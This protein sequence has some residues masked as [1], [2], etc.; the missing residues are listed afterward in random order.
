MRRAVLLALPVVLALAS[1]AHA[2][3]IVVDTLLRGVSGPLCDIGD[4]LNAAN[5]DQP[6]G[7][8]Q[9][10]DPSGA[11]VIDLTGL[12]GVIEIEGN[13]LPVIQQDVTL[14]GPG[15]DLLTIDGGDLSEI[16][17]VENGTLTVE[18]LTIANGNS[19]RGGCIAVNGAGL[20]LRD[21]RVTSCVGF[22]GGGISVDGGG[23]ARIE[24]SLLDGNGTSGNSG[25][26]I[27]NGGSTLEIVSST[28][29]GN[30]TTGDGRVGGG[31]ATF[32]PEGPGLAT[33]RIRSSTIA[34]NGADEGGNVYTEPG[35]GA[36]TILSH[37]L[38]AG[39]RLG[40]NCGGAVASQGWNLSTDATCALAGAGDRPNAV[41]GITALTDAGGATALHVLEAGSAAIDGGDPAGCTDALGAP[42]PFDQ[43]G[44][45]FARRSDGNL[46]GS[47]E[48]D[49]GAYE[50]QTV[51]EPLATASGVAALAALAVAARAR[52]G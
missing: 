1:H 26:G 24:R 31:V 13:V 51:P 21:S 14:R 11:D 32:A 8:C 50:L 44:A 5:E 6:S 10:V 47:F 16:F 43:R 45:G 39:A 41:A 20:V 33:T 12:A 18:G 4:A 27:V 23:S 49:I 34:D 40:G 38:L 35:E 17:V 28:I 2:A 19:G 30:V 46:D 7:G 52:R 48:C 29:S 9:E 37:A 3:V 15:A 25:A 22:N 42:I 36:V